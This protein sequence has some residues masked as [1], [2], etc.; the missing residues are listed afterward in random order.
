[1]VEM[2]LEYLTTL[3]NIHP[4]KTV[5]LLSRIFYNQRYFISIHSTGVKEK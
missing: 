2:R 4:T 3:Q 1:M 5:K